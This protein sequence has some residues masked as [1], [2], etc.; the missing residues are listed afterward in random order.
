MKKLIVC[1]NCGAEYSPFEVYV[2]SNYFYDYVPI[3][4]D[5]NGKI[6]ENLDFDFNEDYQCDYCNEMI[7]ISPKIEFECST[8]SSEKEHVTK[9]KKPSLFLDEV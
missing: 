2:P 9:L 6:L 3:D 7:H 5:E 1:P 4:K 8:E